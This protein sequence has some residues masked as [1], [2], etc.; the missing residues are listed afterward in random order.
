MK[1][2]L[3]GTR[4]HVERLSRGPAWDAA[5][6]ARALKLYEQC[7]RAAPDASRTTA[8]PGGW[9]TA[10][11]MLFFRQQLEAAR[12]ARY[13]SHLEG[14]E[15][16]AEFAE[17]R[18][19]MRSVATSFLGAHGLPAGQAEE[20]ARTSPLFVWASVHTGGSCHPPHV[21]SDAGV[22]GTYYARRPEGSAPL[23][24]DDPRGRSPYDLVA[25]LES[26]LRYGE[27]VGGAGGEAMPPFDGEHV[28]EPRTGECVVFPPWVVHSVP[29]T[30]ADGVLRVSYSFNLLGGWDATG[31]PQGG[32]ASEG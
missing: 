28:I 2:I 18:A 4:V 31:R 21:H 14:F 26:R 7:W 5:L 3:F 12:G 11:N 20:L 13:E 27:E 6:V 17:L 19:C 9:R 29:Q 10:A 32:A 16:C 24:L 15:R 1:Q 25:G 30:T 22:T 23:V 8:L